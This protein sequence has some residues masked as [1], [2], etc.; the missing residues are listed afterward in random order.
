[1]RIFWVLQSGS[2]VKAVMADQWSDC[3][4]GLRAISKNM[5][6]RDANYLTSR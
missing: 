4:T 1:M 6:Q 3:I 2:I 5:K